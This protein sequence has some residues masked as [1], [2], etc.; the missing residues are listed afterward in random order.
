MC[1]RVYIYTHVY[2]PRGFR[3]TNR[4]LNRIRGSTGVPRFYANIDAPSR[5][6]IALALYAPC[7]APL[8]ARVRGIEFW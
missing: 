8:Q 3:R 2:V 7:A 1:H 5:D 4:R 6:A